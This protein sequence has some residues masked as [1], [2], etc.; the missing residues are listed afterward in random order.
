MV[1]PASIGGN[2][3][4]AN[5]PAPRRMVVALDG[6]EKMGKT[7]WALTA[8]GPI[9]I[10]NLDIGAEGVIQ[11]FQSEKQIWLA[12]YGVRPE[13]GD[14]QDKV[15]QRAAP[16]WENFVKDWKDVVVPALKAK[17]I[18]T[19]IWDTGSE[20]WELQRLARFGK[21][22]QILPHNYTALNAEYQ[23]LIREV[24]ETT[25]NLIILH[26]LK[27]EWKDNPATGKGNKTGQYERA[28]YAGTGFLVQINA[29]VWRERKPTDGQTSGPTGSFHLTVRDC[30]QNPAVAGLDLVDEM[31]TFPWLGVHVYPDSDLSEWGG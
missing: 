5:E 4:L 3:A 1:K 17:T 11:K 26:K 25:G 6:L 27:A 13:K 19:A 18:R 22:T 21:L 14:S 29:T 15:M 12:E 7:S 9:A 16:E 28:G 23:G 31:A 10:Q 20:I 2:F 8:P 30:R 24:Y